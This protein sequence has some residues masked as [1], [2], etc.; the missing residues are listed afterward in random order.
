M[1]RLPHVQFGCSPVVGVA[2]LVAVLGASLGVAPRVA[3]QEQE[4]EQ[5]SQIP[6][7]IVVTAE[8]PIPSA[9]PGVTVVD[10]TDLRGRGDA[11][12]A[13]VLERVP[14]VSIQRRGSRFEPST[15]RIRGSTAEQVLVLRDGRP[16]SDSRGGAVDLS[17]ISLADVE[18]I[19]IIRGAATA[20]YGEGG[21]AG[22]VNLITSSPDSSS[23]GSSGSSRVSWGSFR[24][25][26]LEGLVEVAV[27]DA[28]TV[29]AAGSGVLSDNRYDYRRAQDEAVRINGGG[30]Q[31]DLSLSLTA[32]TGPPEDRSGRLETTI[33]AG[34]SERG[35]AGSVEFPSATAALAEAGGAFGAE[36]ATFTGARGRGELSAHAGAWLRERAFRDPEYPLGAVDED[37]GS[38]RVGWGVGIEGALTRTVRFNLTTS[39]SAERM[40]DSELGQRRR[41]RLALAPEVR[42]RWNVGDAGAVRAAVQARGELIRDDATTALPSSRATVAWRSAV[43]DSWEMEWSAAVGNAYRLPSFSELFWPTGAF[44]VGNPALEPEKSRTAEVSTMFEIPGR[45][46][47]EVRGHGA[48]YDGLIQWIPDPR[49]VWQPRNTGAARIVGVELV[50]RVV[51][52][53]GVTPW[54]VSF[55]ATGEY[56]EALDRNPGAT[57]NLTLPYRPEV[58][59]GGEVGVTHLTG[60]ALRLQ[61][62]AVGPRPVTAANTRWLDPYFK[63]NLT[64]ELHVPGTPAVIGGAVNNVLDDR[65][66]E[67]RFFPNPGREFLLFAEVTW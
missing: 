6:D 65:F 67:T 36:F 22:A 24:E 54:E 30:R 39:G 63:L 33:R 49:G 8:A 28:V 57:E 21:A 48:W 41:E 44:A 19:E 2:L 56:L 43:G 55:E 42:G 9:D 17:R 5:D 51:R 23:Q 53:L 27:S 35:L 61:G 11:T 4:R 1:I 45:V 14:S 13:D 47:A 52:P 40:D 15:L 10:V 18:R 50:G 66:V 34:G 38:R 31:G 60:H 7:T 58:S 59:G 62:E 64:G 37:A 32:L 12:V 16:L 3:A 25:G 26:R 46:S 29:S 20:L